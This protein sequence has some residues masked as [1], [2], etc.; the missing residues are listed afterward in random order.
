MLSS[1][2]TQCEEIVLWCSDCSS[3][4]VKPEQQMSGT[5]CAF[6]CEVKTVSRNDINGMADY[7]LKLHYRLCLHA[8][9]LDRFRGLSLYALNH[10]IYDSV[11]EW[12]PSLLTY[13]FI[14]YKNALCI[15]YGMRYSND[16]CNRNKFLQNLYFFRLSQMLIENLDWG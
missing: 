10:Y 7:S 11:L 13:F 15:R 6:L 3:W 1:L 12:I 2:T 16:L 8:R 9:N 4:P 14:S 5:C